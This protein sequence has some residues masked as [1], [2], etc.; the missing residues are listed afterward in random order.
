MR[1]KGSLTRGKTRKR[2]WSIW[3]G[4]KATAG[5]TR[6]GSQS[7]TWWTGRSASTT[8]SGATPRSGRRAHSPEPTRPPRTM[9]RIRSPDPATAASPRLP[10][11]PWWWATSTRPR[12]NCL[13]PARSSRRAPRG[14]WPP[15]RTWTWPGQA[16]G[17]SCPRAPSRAGLCWMAF[18]TKAPRSWTP[19]SRGR[20]TQQPRR[21]RPR[22]RSGPYWARGRGRIRSGWGAGSG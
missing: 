1:L 8:S 2:S 21:R 9:A 11:R 20:R 22:S 19:W 13:P 18:R 5:R 4:E 6:P 14:A 10:P 17:S 15:A 12:A 3:F 7:S 16:T